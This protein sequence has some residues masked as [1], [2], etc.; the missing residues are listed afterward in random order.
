MIN[1]E[2]YKEVFGLEPDIEMCPTK[3]CKDCP[4]Y[5]SSCIEETRNWWNAEYKENKE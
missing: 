1:A 2:K 3:S 4:L 5:R